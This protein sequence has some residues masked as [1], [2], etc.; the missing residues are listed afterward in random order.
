MTTLILEYAHL[1]REDGKLHTAQNVRRELEKN[2]E[3]VTI[4][5]VEKLTQFP[6]RHPF[7]TKKNFKKTIQARGV[8]KAYLTCLE[9]W[10][11]RQLI[12]ACQEMGVKIHYSPH[13]TTPQGRYR[14]T[15]HLWKDS[16]IIFCLGGKAERQQ[17]MR[18]G[19]REENIRLTGLPCIDDANQWKGRRTTG[20]Y[21][22]LLTQPL[23]YHGQAGTIAGQLR[24]TGK[25]ILVRP[26][27]REDITRDYPL[28]RLLR[29]HATFDTNNDKTSLYQDLTDAEIAMSFGST[30]DIEAMI[31]GV[32]VIN[33]T[34]PTT[35][36]Q[37][38]DIDDAITSCT[39]ENLAHAISVA[40]TQ[41]ATRTAKQD[42]YLSRAYAQTDGNA[43]RRV[44][45]LMLE[46]D[47]G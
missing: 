10:I 45:K 19:V 12:K 40:C 23:P 30:T 32:P 44:A 22:L 35:A 11:D 38:A 14:P 3:E 47:D 39:P 5:T 8:T 7:P 41:T 29:G 17:Y 46:E 43:A 28:L 2:D 13:G 37:A 36:R 21:I 25:A 4:V 27:P 1:K 31:I 33:I 15:P 16:D 34:L 20:R 24:K 9:G 6:K 18:R 42:G 26:H